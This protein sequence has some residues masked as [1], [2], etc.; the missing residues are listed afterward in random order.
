WLFGSSLLSHPDY[1]PYFN[2]LA[3]DEPEKILVDSDLDWG[4]DLKRLATRLQQVG[5]D[6]LTF[7]SLQTYDWR[8]QGFP[9]TTDK[10]DGLRPPPGWCAISLTYWKAR[11]LGLGNARPDVTLWPDRIPPTEKVG[12]SIYLWQ[13]PPAR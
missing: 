3:G 11:R 5:A 1:L 12:K 8:S 7:M 2:E 6:R 4:Q 9:L 13:F 10:M